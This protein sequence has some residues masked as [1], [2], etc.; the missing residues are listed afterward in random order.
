M[1]PGSQET[2][3]DTREEK[4]DKNENLSKNIPRWA[5]NTRKVKQAQKIVREGRQNEIANKAEKSRFLI[6]RHPVPMRSKIETRTKL[7]PKFWSRTFLR[8]SH[9]SLANSTHLSQ[10]CKGGDPGQQP[11]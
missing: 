7:N 2:K 4:R 3:E 8:S 10:V 5:N 6:F 1:F 11:N 9:P